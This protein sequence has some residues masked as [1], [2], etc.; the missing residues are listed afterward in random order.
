MKN[1]GLFVLYLLFLF[2]CKQEALTNR[3]C[4]LPYSEPAINIDTTVALTFNPYDPGIL[5]ANK[6]EYFK[7]CF[8]PNNADQVVYN[9]LERNIQEPT[10]QL[11]DFCE[12]EIIALVNCR[13]YTAM[14][15]SI[16]DWIVFV[17][18][19]TTL[20]KIKSNGDSLTRLT[21]KKRDRAPVWDD[22]GER[23][24]YKNGGLSE[25]HTKRLIMADENGITIDT[26]HDL[27]NS[28]AFNWVGNDRVLATLDP[29]HPDYGIGYYNLTTGIYER[30]DYPTFDI[31]EYNVIEHL[32]WLENEQS[33]VWQTPLLVAK[34]NIQ[35]KERTVLAEGFPSKRFYGRFDISED[36]QQIIIHR[37]EWD[38]LNIGAVY[39]TNHLYMMN[40]DGSDRRKVLLPE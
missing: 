36:E 19:D 1:Y 39:E 31:P 18:R 35:T 37:Y 24:I 14:D 2:S 30:I 9:R 32:A 28:T 38:F 40:I 21:Y 33:I 10:L 29:E 8:N 5:F 23:L 3:I 11:F 27:T 16:K 34:T 7:P 25:F 12:G 20:W 4:S 22:W 13:Q 26:L 6:Y 17:A 15:W